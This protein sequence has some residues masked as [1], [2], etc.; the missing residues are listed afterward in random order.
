[1]AEEDSDHVPRPYSAKTCLSGHRWDV[2]EDTAGEPV[3]VLCLICGS[4]R[5][6]RAVAFNVADLLDRMKTTERTSP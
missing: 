2:I 1:M 5:E 4:R 3:A 6:L